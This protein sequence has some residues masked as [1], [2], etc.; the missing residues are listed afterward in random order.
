MKFVLQWSFGV[1]KRCE[2]DPMPCG[3]CLYLLDPFL[4]DESSSPREGLEPALQC[5]GHAFE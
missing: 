3:N 2:I 4:R 5:K 1:V